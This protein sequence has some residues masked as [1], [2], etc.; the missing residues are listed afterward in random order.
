MHLSRYIRIFDV[1][2]FLFLGDC[3]LIEC[4]CL[5]VYLFVILIYFIWV[6][7]WKILL[8]AFRLFDFLRVIRTSIHP[9]RSFYLFPKGVFKLGV[10]SCRR[11]DSYV[12]FCGFFLV[13][14]F[15]VLVYFGLNLILTILYLMVAFFYFHFFLSFV[16]CY[17]SMHIRRIALFI[18]YWFVWVILIGSRQVF[19]VVN[20]FHFLCGTVVSFL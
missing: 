20:N 12:F 18:F 2:W 14:I 11:W 4:I 5:T 9:W 10:L 7:L 3:F 13:D 15:Y 19:S 17:V 16:D 6:L 1:C 8:S